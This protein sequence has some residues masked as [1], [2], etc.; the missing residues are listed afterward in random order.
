[1]K[2]TIIASLL[3]ASL[4]AIGSGASAQTATATST[5]TG[6]AGATAQVQANPA[7][8]AGAYNGGSSAGIEQ[9]FITNSKSQ[10]PVASANPY[11]APS[12]SAQLFNLTL[13]TPISASISASVWLNKVCGGAVYTAGNNGVVVEGEGKSTKTAIQF[14]GRPGSVRPNDLTVTTVSTA[15]PDN[16]PLV[17]GG[18]LSAYGKVDTGAGIVLSDIY[19][20]L[21]GNSSIKGHRQAYV[22]IVNDSFTY[23]LG[24]N[25]TGK[26]GSLGISGSGSGNPLSFLLGAFGSLSS[27]DGEALPVTRVGATAVVLFAP[28]DPSE[29]TIVF[30]SA[31]AVQSPVAEVKPVPQPAVAEVKSSAAVAPQPIATVVTKPA[32]SRIDADIR[33]RALQST[34]K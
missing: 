29:P 26:G 22:Y 31:A 10:F 11:A 15:V 18:V 24:V 23:T 4:L 1:M 3:A 32:A 7:A 13:Q 5:G 16:T 9:S 2:Q 19:S 21:I 8:N 30:P 34:M 14:A 28:V 6:I 20:F 17:C 33:A 27:T 12:G 25:T